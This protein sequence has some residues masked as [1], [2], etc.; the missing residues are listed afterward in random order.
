MRRQLKGKVYKLAEGKYKLVAHVGFNPETGRYERK[1]RTVYG[2]KREAEAALRNWIYELENPAPAMTDMTLAEW[3]HKWCDD[4]A[5]PNWEQ[6]TY[7]RAKGII[8]KNII[9]YAGHIPIGELLPVHVK[10]LYTYL[11]GQ[12]SPRSV[13]YVHT[14]LRQALEEAVRLELLDRNPAQKVSPP[15]DRS[16]AQKNWVVLSAEELKEFLA[17]CQ[18]HRDYALIYTAAYTGA[19]QSELLGL[20]WDNILWDELAIKICTTLH[21]AGRGEYEHRERTKSRTSERTIDVSQDVIAVL[22]EHRKAILERQLGAGIRTDL[23]FTE[24]GGSPI[25]AGNLAHRFVNLAK[26]LGYPG[27]TFHHLRHTHATILLSSG[28]YVNAVSERLGHADPSITLS[29]Y[30]H[31]LPKDRRALADRFHTLMTDMAE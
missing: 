17:G 28:V 5:S 14:I 13:R 30:G 27:M 18:G 22:R 10:D 11:S 29:I 23:V 7:R 4:Y 3:L 25:N 12:L 20:T 24:P 9:P 26:K 15:K 2:T 6:N 31:V 21:R 19:R 1:T 16:R 8:E